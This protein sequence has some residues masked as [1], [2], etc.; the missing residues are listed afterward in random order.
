MDKRLYPDTVTRLYKSIVSDDERQ[1]GSPIIEGTRINAWV[2]AGFVN[3]GDAPEFI[4]ELYGISVEQVN[5]AVIYY[6]KIKNPVKDKIKFRKFSL[7]P[8]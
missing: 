4:A 8:S 1:F 7:T 3:A 2:I 5:D 6:K